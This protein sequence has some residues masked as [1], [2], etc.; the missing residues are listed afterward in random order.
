[1]E[2]NG[3]DGNVQVTNDHGDATASDINGQVDLTIQHGS[4]RLSQIASDVTI[5]GRLDDVS[6]EDVK[7]AVELKGEFSE[8][9]KLTKL[10][11]GFSFRSSR[12]DIEVAKLD[13][14]LEL[15]SGDLRAD[16][17]TGPVR[18]TTRSKDVVLTGV[19]GDVR[20][21]DEN[22]S[23]ELRMNKMGSVQLQNRKGDIQLYLPEKAAF[24]VDGKARDGEV[25]SDFKNLKVENK[26]IPARAR[27]PAPSDKAG[28]AWC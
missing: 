6:V 8:S 14:S 21:T 27:S 20:V 5:E 11:K 13:G 2:V 15:D 18:L 12:S 22:G 4:A 23:V 1:M 24:E 16:E 9:V 7:G 3:R 26:T 17:M 19:N 25:T 28:R 10:A